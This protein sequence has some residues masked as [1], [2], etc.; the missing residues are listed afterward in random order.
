MGGVFHTRPSTFYSKDFDFGHRVVLNLFKLLFKISGKI[1]EVH[2]FFQKLVKKPGT[3]YIYA[4]NAFYGLR[5][6]I[7]MKKP[8]IWKEFCFFFSLIS[9]PALPANPRTPAF[10]L[11]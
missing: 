4:G 5:F 7:F 3:L 2:I 8:G 6:M 11:D 9:R 10:D 1:Y